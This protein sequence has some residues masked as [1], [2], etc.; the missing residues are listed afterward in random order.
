MQRVL[1]NSRYCDQDCCILIHSRLKALAGNLS[2]PSD[3]LW[4]YAGLVRSNNPRWLK[5]DLVVCVNPSSTSSWVWVGEYLLVPAH[6]DRPRQRAIKR[7]CVYFSNKVVV[8]VAFSLWPTKQFLDLWREDCT[9]FWL[10][11]ICSCC[12]VSKLFVSFTLLLGVKTHLQL[13]KTRSACR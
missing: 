5:A 12:V 7:A 11:L 4:L 10:L 9:S 13:R 6:P 3:R 2:W 1:R 8:Y